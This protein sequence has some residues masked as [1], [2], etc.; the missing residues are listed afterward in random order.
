MWSEV[1][2]LGPG[3]VTAGFDSGVASLDRW[4]DEHARGAGGAGSARTYVAADA[5]RRVLGFHAVTAAS[6][7]REEATA[8]VTKGMPRHPIPAVLIARLAVAREAQGRGLGRA[9]LRD[10]LVRAVSASERLGV[11]AVLV[12]AATPQAR[13]FYLRHGFEPSPT[14]ELNLQVLVK[15]VRAALDAP[16]PR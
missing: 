10:A 13:T 14:D 12:H 1:E 7:E 6:I 8:R 11:R 9:L 5:D 3:H 15:D 2:P 4:L 16:T